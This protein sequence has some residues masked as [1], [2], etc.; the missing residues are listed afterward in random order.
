MADQTFGILEILLLGVRAFG[1][2]AAFAAFAWALMRMRRE[3]AE[4][5]EQVLVSQRDLLA[6]NQALSER[7]SALG[8]LLASLP[9]R[10]EPLVESAP[11][12]AP[13]PPSFRKP[14]RPA[15]IPSYETAKRLARNGAS[16][17]EIVASSGVVGT[18]ARLLRRLHGGERIDQ[19]PD[20]TRRNN[21]A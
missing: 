9:R 6:Q 8:T 10:A 19:N 18:E 1:L 15:G 14:R 4:Q 3:H 21:A 2:F 16:V 5:L 13:P 12:M 20:E 11:Q 7:V 17:E